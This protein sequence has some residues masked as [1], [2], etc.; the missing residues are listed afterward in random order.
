M[1]YKNLEAKLRMKKFRDNADTYDKIAALYVTSPARDDIG[2]KEADK[3]GR[4]FSNEAS[5][6]KKAATY[7]EKRASRDE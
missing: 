5:R 2:H 1:G 6:Y 7:L 3:L 4:S